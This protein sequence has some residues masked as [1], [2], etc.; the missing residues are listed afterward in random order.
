M[1]TKLNNWL[2]CLINRVTGTTA[3]AR[4]HPTDLYSRIFTL[5]IFI[6]FF[7]FIVFPFFFFLILHFLI[8]S[9]SFYPNF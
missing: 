2:L 6:H 9:Y 4:L 1:V 7:V 3:M 8:S 5:L